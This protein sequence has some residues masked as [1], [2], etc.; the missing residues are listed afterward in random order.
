MKCVHCLNEAGDTRDHVF[1][2]SWY[3]DNT[4]TTVQRPTVPSC[5]MCNGKLGKIE[6]ELFQKLAVCIDPD[7]DSASGIKEKVLRGF[8][9][10]VDINEMTERDRA[11]RL[12]RLKKLIDQTKPVSEINMKAF[13]GLGPHLTYPIE[14]QRA[15]PAPKEELQ[16]IAEKI[17]RGLEYSLNKRYIE[18]PLKLEA[19]IYITDDK[20]P[21]PVQRVLSLGEQHIYGPGFEVVRAATP[22]NLVVIYK[23][24]VWGTIKI[25]GSIA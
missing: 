4:P 9:L 7:K 16:T 19:Y 3:P 14:I 5:V 20:L 8:G 13:P 25:Y 15:F 6:D 23:F 2:K 21:A 1:P 10:G 17:I 18:A 11:A 24:V 22:S 12:S